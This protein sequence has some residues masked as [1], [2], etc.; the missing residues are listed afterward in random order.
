MDDLEVVEQDPSEGV[1]EPYV[2]NDEGVDS[3]DEE[4]DQSEDDDDVGE[5]GGIEKWIDVKDLKNMSL[6]EVKTFHNSTSENDDRKLDLPITK[7]TV[8]SLI[9]IFA[10]LWVIIKLVFN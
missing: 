1:K 6:E 2:N 10:N 4:D 8:L 5:D 3:F 7:V 9:H